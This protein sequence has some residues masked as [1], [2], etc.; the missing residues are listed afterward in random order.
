MMGAHLHAPVPASFDRDNGGRDQARLGDLAAGTSIS[1]L[2]RLP[3]DTS[4]R[5]DYS[6][7]GNRADANPADRNV[8]ECAVTIFSLGVGRAIPIVVQNC[9]GGTP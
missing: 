3:D 6:V 8:C 5:T 9:A 1:L 7:L 2:A 4:R